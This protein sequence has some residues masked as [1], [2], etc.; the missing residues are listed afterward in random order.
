MMKIKLKYWVGTGCA[1]LFML[2]ITGCAARR[3]EPIRGLLAIDN[4][5]VKEG[6]IVYM[7]HCQKCHPVGESGLGPAINS[8]PAPK[9]VN[10]FQVRHGL[11]MMPAFSEKHIS[12]QDLQ[13]IVQYM[14]ALKRNK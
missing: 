1:L 13:N 7:A 10:K 11:G 3:S 9:F 4:V 12:D 14:A 8:N 5:A 2:S 6:Q